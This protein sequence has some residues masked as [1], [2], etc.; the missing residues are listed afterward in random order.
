MEATA[1][2]IGELR[3]LTGDTATAAPRASSN[4]WWGMLMLIATEAALFAILVASYFYIRWQTSGGWPPDGIPDPKLPRPIVMTVLLIS[5]SVPMYLAERG[6]RRGDVQQL[7]WGLAVSFVLAAAFLGLQ[8][9]EYLEKLKELTPQTNAYGSLFY[10][11][12]G[13]HGIHLTAGLALNGWVQFRAW[14]GAFT[15]R[16]HLAVQITAVYWHFVDAVWLVIFPSLYL[17]PYI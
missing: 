3:R 14:R 6:I 16:R 1:A 17:F 15:A 9:S 7:R 8:A 5:S 4:G 2:K 10:L 11:I 12:T 13:M